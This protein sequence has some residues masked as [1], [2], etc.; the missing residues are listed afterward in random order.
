MAT[1]QSKLIKKEVVAKGTMRFFLEKPEGFSYI[2][3]Q[4]ATF[5]QVNPIETDDEGNNRTF[6]LV[7]IPS[8]DAV[9]FTTRMRDSAFKRNLK[10][11][12][13]GMKIEIIDPRG[14]MVLPNDTKR[15]LAFLAGG[16][17]ITPFISMVREAAHQKSEQN[18]VLFYAN[19]TI[20][21]TAFLQDLTQLAEINPNFTFVPIMTQEDPT[22]WQGEKGH[23]TQEMLQK[24][25]PDLA[26]TIYYLAGP[27][28]MV[29]AMTGTLAQAGV[30]PLFIK[31]EDFGEYTPV[32]EK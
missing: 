15:P 9:A 17:G 21:E 7:S 6:S 30:D 3:G 24:Y 25:V 11:G 19:K 4:H 27:G 14:S 1:F 10:N 29:S 16:I 32:L 23:L 20:E 18:I 13:E 31:S 28:G 5:R 12:P 2:P 8:D 26:N 22:T